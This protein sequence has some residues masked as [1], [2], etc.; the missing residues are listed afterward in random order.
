MQSVVILCK[1]LESYVQMFC[2]V[3]KKILKVVRWNAKV[4]VL[5]KVLLKHKV[6]QYCA[7]QQMHPQ[8][9]IITSR[10]LNDKQWNKSCKYLHDD[11]VEHKK[12]SYFIQYCKIVTFW[13]YITFV[14]LCLQVLYKI[15]Q[16]SIILALRY[17]QR[18]VY[19]ILGSE[20]GPP[21]ISSNSAKS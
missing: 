14:E 7:K 13:L 4:T 1:V 15:L 17:F 12:T 18:I 9:C 3:T 19:P 11:K 5:Q 2:I 6:L 10:S 8:I 16:N 21:E 20:S